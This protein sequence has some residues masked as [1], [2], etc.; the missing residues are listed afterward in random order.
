MEEQNQNTDI[1]ISIAD[2]ALLKKITEIACSRGAFR[3]EEMTQIGS[4]YDRVSQW[5]A[6]ITESAEQDSATEESSDDE[7]AETQGENDA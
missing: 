2:I 3:A 7:S 4:V 5:L 1:S 6:S